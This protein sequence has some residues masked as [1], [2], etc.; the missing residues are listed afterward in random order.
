MCITCIPTQPDDQQ[1]QNAINEAQQRANEE[2]TP[3]A[4]YKDADGYKVAPAFTAFAGGVAPV[5]CE[6]VSPY[7]PH[8]FI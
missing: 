3:M 1:K 8:A 7:Y 5:V 6:I 2:K 4:V